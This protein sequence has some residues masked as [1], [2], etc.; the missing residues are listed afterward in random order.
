MAKHERFSSV[1]DALNAGLENL[2]KWYRKIGDT[3]T[4]FVCLGTLA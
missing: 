4:Y 2:N 3:D 1:A